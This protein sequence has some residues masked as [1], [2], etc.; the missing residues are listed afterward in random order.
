MVD[1]EYTVNNTLEDVTL[2]GL[3][4]I[5]KEYA[6]VATWYVDSVYVAQVADARTN[7]GTTDV[8][9]GKMWFAI[10]TGD[11]VTA[12]PSWEVARE[13]HSFAAQGWKDRDNWTSKMD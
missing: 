11:K 6:I 3:K 9:Q 1:G 7:N 13:L 8:L 4:H 12:Q 5:V 10:C 2:C